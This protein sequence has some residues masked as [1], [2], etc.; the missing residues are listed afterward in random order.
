M[1]FCICNDTGKNII[2]QIQSGNENELTAQSILN[3]YCSGSNTLWLKTERFAYALQPDDHPFVDY[4]NLILSTKPENSTPAT[5]FYTFP[6]YDSTSKVLYFLPKHDTNQKIPRLTIVIPQS[7]L[8]SDLTQLST[9]IEQ[10]FITP[11]NVK[12]ILINDEPLNRNITINDVFENAKNGKEIAVSLSFDEVCIQKIR[13]RENLCNEIVYSENNFVN[14]LTVINNDW[15]KLF[16]EENFLAETDFR[17]LFND[18]PMILGVHTKFSQMLKE[19]LDG[20]GS[21]FSVCFIQYHP[22]FKSSINYITNYPSINEILTLKEN[23]QDY[24]KRCKEM[25]QQ[26]K[27]RDLASYLITPV[28]RIPRY[29]LFLRELSKLTPKNHPDYLYLSQA[30]Q[31]MTNLTQEID[32]KTE[33]AEKQN[34]LYNIQLRNYT[35]FVYCAPARKVIKIYDTIIKS[36]SLEGNLVVCDDYVFLIDKPDMYCRFRAPLDAFPVD[37]LKDGLSFKV[38]NTDEPDNLVETTVQM[39]SKEE[40]E[41]FQKYINDASINNFNSTSGDNESILWEV[42]PLT[43]RAPRLCKH[44]GV[45]VKNKEEEYYL[46]YGGYTVKS[47]EHV[48][49]TVE[50]R[51]ITYQRNN[52]IYCFTPPDQFKEISSGIPGRYNHRL[53]YVNNKFFIIGGSPSSQTFYVYD[54]N[55]QGEQLGWRKV[56]APELDLTGHAAVQHQNRIYIYG[57]TPFKDDVYELNTDNYSLKTYNDFP[58]G[59]KP[60]QRTNHSAV[61]YNNKLYVYGGTDNIGRPLSDLWCFD[62]ET[63]KWEMKGNF[64]S[65][66]AGHQGLLLGNEYVIVGG[67]PKGDTIS[68]NLDT[69]EKKVVKDFGNYPSGLN[70]FAVAVGDN[71]TALVYGGVES[72]SK[73]PKNTVY[74]LKLNNDWNQ[75]ATNEE[76]KNS[77]L[78]AEKSQ[79]TDREP[80]ISSFKGVNLD[81]DDLPEAENNEIV[82]DSLVTSS[83]LSE[84]LAQ[85]PGNGDLE[86]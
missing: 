71:N 86:P 68:I 34:V 74:T 43:E 35:D 1:Y 64:D 31:T 7:D 38:L 66:K 20:Y 41:E 40:L 60:E 51:T 54:N 72:T 82:D 61:I 70:G 2:G 56:N 13:Q 25:A 6:N 48:D 83:L 42:S 12:E 28:Q 57:G 62:L 73:S 67:R 5:A 32:R 36:R 49:D 39:N 24:N 65:P 52:T 59:Q 15:K 27:G 78:V 33:T 81:V 21:Q 29:L 85:G 75:K 69:L 14:D 19:N 22:F 63:K 18:I 26:L 76:S 84:S 23:Q 11:A 8:G 16:E 37:F 50:T 46:F 10:S 79:Q 80:I 53:V 4:P 9:I 45:Y 3:Q 17:A 77:E 58:E 44:S 30:V 55:Q 47:D